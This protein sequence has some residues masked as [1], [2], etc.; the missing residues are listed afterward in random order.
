VQLLHDFRL[1]RRLRKVHQLFETSDEL[2][3]LM[4]RIEGELKVHSFF[5]MDENF[6]LH[7]TRGPRGAKKGDWLQGIPTNHPRSLSAEIGMRLRASSTPS[8]SRAPQSRNK[9][10]PVT[11]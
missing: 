11:A 10:T 8:V 6:L 4:C 3:E 9:V 5:M 7:R 1:L 2:F